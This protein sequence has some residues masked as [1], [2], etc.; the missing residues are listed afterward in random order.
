MERAWYGPNTHSGRNKKKQPRFKLG[1]SWRVAL[2]AF[3][4]SRVLFAYFNSFGI[5]SS[6]MMAKWFRA[7]FQLW[8]ALVQRFEASLMAR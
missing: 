1:I 3:L 6:N 4:C 7:S 2:S 8:I 5:R